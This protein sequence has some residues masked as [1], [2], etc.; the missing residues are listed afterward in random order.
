MR[1]S[2]CVRCASVLTWRC[3]P[4][5][6]CR[7]WSESWHFGCS[8]LLQS[9]GI[10]LNLA[11]NYDY[12]LL[13]LLLQS[14]VYHI[15][16]CCVR[17][18]VNAV[19]YANSFFFKQSTVSSRIFLYHTQIIRYTRE[20]DYLNL[21]LWKC[22]SSTYSSPWCLTVAEEVRVLAEQHHQQHRSLLHNDTGNWL[23]LVI[24]CWWRLHI[25]LSYCSSTS[26]EKQ[27][28]GMNTYNCMQFFCYFFLDSTLIDLVQVR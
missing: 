5:R 13:H 26:E 8:S 1:L 4:V 2:C 16:H 27:L 17:K 28:K 20:S 11:G 24:D 3:A 18:R 6:W 15:L 14:F 10:W 9:Q 19:I 12:M 22:S 7:C 25:V 23:R 21:P